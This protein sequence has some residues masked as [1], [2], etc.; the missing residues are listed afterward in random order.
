MDADTSQAA[1]AALN[2]WSGARQHVLVPFGTSTSSVF[3]V[4]IN[5]ATYFLRVTRQSF[6]SVGDTTE[7]LSFLQHL[8]SECAH[9]AMPVPSIHDRGVEK[10]GDWLATLFRRAPGLR[11][12]PESRLWDRAFFREWGRTL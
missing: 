10:V 4:R 11:L 7:E 9:V 6:R 2:L 12:T 1:A 5:G 3:G 8:H